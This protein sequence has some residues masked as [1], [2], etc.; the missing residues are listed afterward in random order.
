M[1]KDELVEIVWRGLS[2]SDSTISARINAARKA[3]GDTGKS[4]SVIKTVHGRGFQLVAGVETENVVGRTEAASQTGQQTIRFVQSSNGARIAYAQSGSGPP[5]VRIGHWLSHLELDW[6]SPVWLPLVEALGKNH[7]LYRYD[8]RGTGLSSRGI[9]G[10]GLDAFVE[11]LESVANAN[12]LKSFPIFAAS[13]AVPVAVRFAERFPERIS[14]LVLYGGYVKG[15]A[16]R[17]LSPDDVDESTVL[18]LIRAG[19]GK[20]DS[21]FMSALSSLY[22]PDATPG[23]LSSFVKMQLET[24]TPDKAATLR[25]I[26]DRFDVQDSLRSIKAPTLVVH[27]IDDAINPIEQGRILASEIPNARFLPLESRNHVP[28]PQEESWGRMMS[29]VTSFLDQLR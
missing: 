12:N 22:M 8:Q 9:E 7:T 21:P 14:G 29:E 27:A 6:R 23:Q 4:Q 13:Q 2:V 16:L 11:D 19:W 25:Q 10:A 1:T 26:V 24:I 5:L 20:E 28:L 3:V 17:S 18:A 15:R